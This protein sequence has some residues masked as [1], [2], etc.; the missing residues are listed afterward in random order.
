MSS[1]E[2]SAFC[3]KFKASSYIHSDR[4][5]I[6]KSYDITVAELCERWGMYTGGEFKEDE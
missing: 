6:I 4:D 3:E 2:R 1:A 5:R